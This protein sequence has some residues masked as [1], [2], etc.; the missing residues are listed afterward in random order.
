MNWIDYT[1]I[2]I[3]FGTITYAIKFIKYNKDWKKEGNHIFFITVLIAAICFGPIGLL[4]T[5]INSKGQPFRNM[6]K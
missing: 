5:L 6:D 3:A 2:W 4:L 1:I